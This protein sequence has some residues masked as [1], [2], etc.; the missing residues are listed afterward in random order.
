MERRRYKSGA[1]AILD[2][3]GTGEMLG[4]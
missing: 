2:R 4:G 3:K 1:G